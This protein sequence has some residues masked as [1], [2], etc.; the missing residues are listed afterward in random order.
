MGSSASSEQLIPVQ[1]PPVV[2]GQQ[3]ATGVSQPPAA[4]QIFNLSTNW[5]LW[6]IILILVI[7]LVLFI[8]KN[9]AMFNGSGVG[10]A[11]V[12]TSVRT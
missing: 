9:R 5:L 8:Y 1:Q 2:V 6:I 12:R 3:A 10:K 7:M 4:I 11:S